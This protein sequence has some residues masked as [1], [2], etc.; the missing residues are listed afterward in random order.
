MSKWNA[1]KGKGPI[2][3]YFQFYISQDYP[4]NLQTVFP[5]F[6]VPIK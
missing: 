4:G 3:G 5:M 1:G 2:Y 6:A